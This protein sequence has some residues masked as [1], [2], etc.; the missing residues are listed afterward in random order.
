MKTNFMQYHLHTVHELTDFNL[1][2]FA[3]NF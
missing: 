2:V 1:D 3:S